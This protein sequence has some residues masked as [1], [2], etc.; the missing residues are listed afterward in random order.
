MTSRKLNNSLLIILA[1]MS[2]CAVSCSAPKTFLKHDAVLYENG[3]IAIL[4]VEAPSF[5]ESERMRLGDEINATLSSRFKEDYQFITASSVSKIIAEHNA[6]AIYN[7]VQSN[8]AAMNLYGTG[9]WDPDLY[10]RFGNALEVDYL[11]F[12]YIVFSKSEG[13]VPFGQSWLPTKNTAVLY[14]LQ[15]IDCSEGQLL[16]ES[17]YSEEES[18]IFSQPDE[19]KIARKLIKK[20][21]KRF[22]QPNSKTIIESY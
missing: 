7:E 3:I 5:M 11:F 10:I 18:G 16:W 20:G 14:L 2:L 4:P 21:L 12:S 13:L 1:A 15:L 6:E 8:N 17:K 9:S 19:F 22:P